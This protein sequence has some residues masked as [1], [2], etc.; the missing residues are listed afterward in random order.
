MTPGGVTAAV[1]TAEATAGEP[2][3]APAVAPVEGLVGE[4]G[5]A[6]AEA[7]E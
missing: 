1:A 4:P 7:T 5:E 2:E 3:E 6:P